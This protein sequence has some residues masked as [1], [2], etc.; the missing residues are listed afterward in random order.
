MELHGACGPDQAYRLTWHCSS[1]L[2]SEKVSTTFI[3]CSGRINREKKEEVHVVFL[4]KRRCACILM[5]S[6][7]QKVS[8]LKASGYG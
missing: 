3:V 5:H 7:K 2:W 8:L 4:H 1:S 6:T